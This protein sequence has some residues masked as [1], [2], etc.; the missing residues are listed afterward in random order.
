MG[1]TSLITLALVLFMSP[2]AHC[3]DMT[4]MV[5]TLDNATVQAQDAHNT[6]LGSISSEHSGNSIF[7]DFGA[8]G[9]QNQLDSVWNPLWVF[10]SPWSP[11]SS[12]NEF[13][14]APPRIIKD[15]AVIGYL[16]TNPD[17]PNRIN[18]I[19]LKTLKP[20]FTLPEGC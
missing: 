3:E 12:S 19:Q 5:R 17:F 20:L 1:T 15:G 10:G 11:W 2:L 16:T 18:P 14:S 9:G 4:D 13:A 6:Y 7:N 8:H